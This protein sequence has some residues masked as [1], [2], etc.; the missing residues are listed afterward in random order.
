MEIDAQTT[1]VR[2][3][4]VITESVHDDVVV[5]DPETSRYVRL[6]RAAAL[7]WDA[8]GASSATVEALADVL[9]ARLGAPAERA[10]PDALAFT[11]AMADRGLVRLSA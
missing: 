5:L 7:L 2:R 9:Q 4:D 8:L 11:S 3:A 6:N 1:V 10:L